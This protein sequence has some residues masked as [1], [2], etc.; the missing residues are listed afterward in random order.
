MDSNILKLLEDFANTPG[1]EDVLYLVADEMIIS[2]IAMLC[3]IDIYTI[4]LTIIAF[5]NRSITH[6]KILLRMLLN[7]KAISSEYL[8]KEL[9]QYKTSLPEWVQEVFKEKF[10]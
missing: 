10:S 4:Y 7:L 6:G 9:T 1:N 3:P 5:P 2:K 8:E